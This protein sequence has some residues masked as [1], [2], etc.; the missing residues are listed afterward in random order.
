M[1]SMRNEDLYSPQDGVKRGVKKVPLSVVLRK[2]PD[3]AI[4]RYILRTWIIKAL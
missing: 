3:R 4:P 1:V 2:V